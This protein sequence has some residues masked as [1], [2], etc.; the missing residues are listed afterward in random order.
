MAHD[1]GVVSDLTLA[2]FLS[3]C[4]ADGFKHLKI[5]FKDPKVVDGCV[6]LLNAAHVDQLADN[7]QGVWLNADVLPL[8]LPSKFDA[9]AFVKACARVEGA[10]PSLGW[11][12]DLRADASYSDAAIDAMVSL[13][14]R[15][16]L[17]EFVVAANLRMVL[18]DIEPL[19][20]LMAKCP[21]A[22]LLLWTGSGEPS[23]HSS[24]VAAATH[25]LRL[26]PGRLG[27]DVVSTDSALRGKV[28]DIAISAARFYRRRA[29]LF[30]RADQDAPLPRGKTPKCWCA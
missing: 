12:V 10:V 27:F 22:M 15:H 8:S 5:D 25:A 13:S 29:D 24:A 11:R 6:D 30:R 16:G 3:L 2:T 4:V 1:A 14:R 19:K 23:I 28:H 18:A 20:R 26:G 17:E 7:A 9:D 21:K